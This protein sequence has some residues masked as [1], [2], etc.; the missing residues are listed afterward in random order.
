MYALATEVTAT[1]AFQ[2]WSSYD[3]HALP[4]ITQV[5][6]ACYGCSPRECRVFRAFL[7][8]PQ[9]PQKSSAPA[10]RGRERAHVVD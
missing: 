3:R 6:G 7:V 2:A 1:L 4:E 9:A 10:A 5:M 8:R